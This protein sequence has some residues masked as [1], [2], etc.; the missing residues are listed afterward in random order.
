MEIFVSGCS[1]TTYYFIE[2][3][4]PYTQ[5][6][7]NCDSC[8]FR[9][10]NWIE[11]TTLGALIRSLDLNE[12]QNK[13]VLNCTALKECYHK[14][15]I[16]LIWGPPGTGKTKTLASF[17]FAMLKNNCRVVTCA[18][19]NVAVVEVTKRLFKIAL[20]S[21]EYGTYGLGNIVLYG[22]GKRM[23]IDDHAELFDVFLDF[24]AHMLNKCLQPTSGWVHCLDSLICL[25]ENPQEQYRMYLQD[26]SMKVDD[27]AEHEEQ[28]PLE[29]SNGQHK[30]TPKI[31]ESYKR[32]TWR[33]IIE[34]TIRAG[35]KKHPRKVVTQQ[36][37]APE[38][39]RCERK[40]LTF[41]EYVKRKLC[42]LCNRLK[43][44]APVLYT[45]LPTS[46]IL[47]KDVKSMMNA[48]S[49]L[50][51][52]CST[53]SCNIVPN[54]ETD[55]TKMECLQALK[56]LR[57]RF[58]VPNIHGIYSIK[59]FC[60]QH[61]KL[62]F[63]TASSSA[64]LYDDGPRR[65]NIVVIDEAAQLKECESAIPLQIPGLRHAILIGD[66]QQLPAMVKSKVYSTVSDFFVFIYLFDFTI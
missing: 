16:K 5:V 31:S 4:P 47:I 8:F 39:D 64:R 2:H 30:V 1:V 63:C 52:L 14:S 9:E 53:F 59:N 6:C 27:D 41:E 56:D 48:L 37:S 38:F 35:N 25:I 13:A 29:E 50:D 60:L 17:L 61:G 22:N 43:F 40:K 18:P 55:I 3:F 24:R 15:T 46:F 49:L 23:K 42:F 21:F 58:D 32:R 66:E 19:T 28:H 62:Y 44:Y 65:I 45:H 33:K 10:L 20:K 51:N 7:S 54:R 34:E 12:S 57:F 11:S 26:E 36:K